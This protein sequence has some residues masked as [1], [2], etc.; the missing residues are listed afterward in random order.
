MKCIILILSAGSRMI[1]WE[2][3]R[4]EAQGL[5]LMAVDL[6]LPFII[7][8]KNYDFTL[9]RRKKNNIYFYWRY[10]LEFI[11]G[12]AKLKFAPGNTSEIEICAGRH[13][14]K[15]EFA[16]HNTYYGSDTVDLTQIHTVCEWSNRLIETFFLGRYTKSNGNNSIFRNNENATK[17]L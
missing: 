14:V 12:K 1:Q 7:F 11:Y 10:T 15:L 8:L 6:P 2:Y 3:L 16:P 17:I 13:I 5:C 9:F 4:W